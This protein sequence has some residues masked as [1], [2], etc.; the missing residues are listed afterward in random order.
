[1]SPR[2]PRPV[3]VRGVGRGEGGAV[4]LSIDVDGLY[5]A[6]GPP[7]KVLLTADEARM[8]AQLI[9]EAAGHRR[10]GDPGT[11]RVKPAD[12]DDDAE[13]AV[14]EAGFVALEG[15]GKAIGRHVRRFLGFRSSDG[16]ADP[17]APP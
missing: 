4:V 14:L 12:P 11:D 16:A 15:C 17:R 3:R 1:M 5:G 2:D 9:R 13:A 7:L 10:A 6:A 8:T